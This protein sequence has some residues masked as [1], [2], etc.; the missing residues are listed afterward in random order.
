MSLK[1]QIEAIIYAAEDPVTLDQLVTLLKD[2]IIALEQQGTMGDEEQSAEQQPDATSE[3]AQLQAGDAADESGATAGAGVEAATTEATETDSASA[4]NT[5]AADAVEAAALNDAI[6]AEPTAESAD[7]ETA[8]AAD[9]IDAET[10]NASASETAPQDTAEFRNDADETDNQEPTTDD[11]IEGEVLNPKRA[12]REE[13]K[14]HK[15]LVRDTVEQLIC[16]YDSADRGIEI[17]E[18]AGGYRMSTKPEHHDLVRSFAKGT[19]PPIKLSLPAL[20]TLAVIAYK[21][22]VTAPEISEIRG[23]DSSG[24]LAS[25]ISRK[26][27]TTAGRKQVVG[28]PILYKTTKEFLMRFGLKDVNELPSMEEFEKISAQADMFDPNDVA[29]PAPAPEPEVTEEP[30]TGAIPEEFAE[31]VNEEQPQAEDQREQEHV[32][33]S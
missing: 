10:A 16:E 17:R 28:R 26:L 22:P 6:S 8:D 31:S 33:E 29:E 11:Q 13:T 32:T 1:A 18:I 14:R 7:S 23:V 12:Q 19:K 5:E 2:E 24:V 3:P 30:T 21:Q 15:R 27:I 4:E 20:E 9:S 25:L